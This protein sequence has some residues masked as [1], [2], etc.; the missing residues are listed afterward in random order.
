MV[1]QEDL[2]YLPYNDQN[3]GRI[4]TRNCKE[5]IKL[6]IKEF[7]ES[8]F[9]SR[10]AADGLA[11]AEHLDQILAE[12][13]SRSVATISTCGVHPNRKEHVD[14]WRP[15]TRAAAGRRSS[16]RA[17]ADSIPESL[18]RVQDLHGF[19]QRSGMQES[20]ARRRELPIVSQQEL[21]ARD[22]W[23]RCWRRG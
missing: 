6:F 7:R 13:Q 9:G 5:N 21:A 11:T 22:G 12:T 17:T 2:Q 14:E 20:R 23:N 3:L 18:A 19:A 8:E 15:G 10:L 1:T 16:S 4:F